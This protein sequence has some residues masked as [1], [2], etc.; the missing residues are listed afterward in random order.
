[1]PGIDIGVAVN[2]PFPPCPIPCIGGIGWPDFEAAPAAFEEVAWFMASAAMGIP[3]IPG[4]PAPGGTAPRGIAPGGIAPGGIAPGG[5]APFPIIPG[6]IPIIPP[7]G[8]PGLFI[9]GGMPNPPGAPGTGGPVGAP[10]FGAEPASC[11]PGEPP[12]SQPDFR[13]AASFAGD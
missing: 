3:I 10:D 6:F 12:A 9:F 5:I 13:G 7:C 4:G 11:S 2:P 1:M 8:G